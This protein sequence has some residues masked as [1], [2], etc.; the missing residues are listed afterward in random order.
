MTPRSILITGCGS[1]I[2][3]H[4]AHALAKRGWRVFATCRRQSDCDRLA[5]EGLE[6]VRLDYSDTA[7]IAAALDHV[8]AAT[9]GRL[10]ALFN[11]GGFSLPGALEDLSADHL[12]AVLEANFIGWH[13]LTRRVVPVMR[14]Q[15]AGRIV[16][17]SSILGF[18]AVRFSGAYIAAKFAIEGWSDTLRLEL[19]GTGIRVSII[20]PGP[21]ASNMLADARDRFMT[22]IDSE[23]SSFRDDYAK[24]FGRLSSGSRSSRFQRSPQAI[25][26]RL[27]HAVESP[28][29]RA[30]YRVTIPTRFMALMKRLLTTAALDR[31]L[32]RER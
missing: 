14:A 20:E 17:C 13:D 7:S 5:G 23:N 28:R 1:G 15:G 21:I 24:E 3:Y 2:G 4:C 8:L 18:V 16:N 22:A 25:C 9:G 27:V 10:D 32:A 11:N 31:I 30:R 6:T 29:P 19:R 26:T 12:R